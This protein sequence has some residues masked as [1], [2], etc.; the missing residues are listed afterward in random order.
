MNARDFSSSV[1]PGGYR[2]WYVDAMSDDGRHG[3]T[4]IA[5]IGSVFSPYYASARRRTTGVPDPQ[6]FCSVNVALYGEHRRWTMTERGRASLCRSCDELSIG[7]SSLG[8]D[9]DALVIQLDERS[10]PLPQRVRGSIRL[11]APALSRDTF[12]LDAN[13]HH[14]W[15]PIAPCARVS[16]TLEHPSLKWHGDG[17]LDSNAGDSPLEDAFARWHW[18]RSSLHGGDTAVLYDVTRRDGSNASIALHFDADGGYR[19]FE[20]PPERTL[21]AT[22]WRIGRTT[23]SDDDGAA[24]RVRTLEDTPFYARSLVR[25]HLLGEPVGSV[26]ESLD[27]DR[28][29]SRWVQALLPFRM[30]RRVGRVDT[31]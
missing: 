8:W 13:G 1:P 22:L 19:R 30:P 11:R 18:S 16:V 27:L 14:L 26:H 31:R 24:P 10:S 4:V 28:F 3:L 25:T 20:P 23:R 7:P 12:A 5:F 2:W 15:S 9:G 21:P 29:G 6:D 17:Y